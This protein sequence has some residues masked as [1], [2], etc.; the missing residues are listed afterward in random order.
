[1]IDRKADACRRRDVLGIGDLLEIGF[2]RDCKGEEQVIDDIETR[3]HQMV[4]HKGIAG[5]DSDQADIFQDQRTPFPDLPDD[6]TD[7]GGDPDIRD[8]IDHVEQ[9]DGGD[10][11]SELVD[12]QEC[13]EDHENLPPGAPH[14]GE[15][16]VKPI[17]FAQEQR[18][19]LH[20]FGF[21]ERVVEAAEGG[22]REGKQAG[23]QIQRLISQVQPR[24]RVLDPQQP[25]DQKQQFFIEADHDDDE[26]RQGSDG[27]RFQL[28]GQMHWCVLLI[29]QLQ[30][31]RLVHRL[32][33]VKPERHQK[34]RGIQGILAW[35]VSRD[36]R[37]DT[38]HGKRQEG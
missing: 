15:R 13:R 34:G 10:V 2:D 11:V 19:G 8:Q 24:E 4:V 5:E 18:L 30:G 38:Q 6:P 22:D 7:I 23:D 1:M 20:L 26:N 3:R 33:I 36:R 37:P 35:E 17:A 9:R 27:G 32:V 16:V 28:I 31:Q 29:D 21:E 25:L 12:H 14:E